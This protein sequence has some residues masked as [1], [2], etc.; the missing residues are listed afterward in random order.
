MVSG[1]HD[2]DLVIR[3]IRAG[4]NNYVAKPI[5]ARGLVE[6]IWETVGVSGA[7]AM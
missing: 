4:V 7:V 3:A 6:K 5:H 1:E 2:P